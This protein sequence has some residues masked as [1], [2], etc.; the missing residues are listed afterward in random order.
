MA[1]VVREGGKIHIILASNPV[2]ATS[3]ASDIFFL[4]RFPVYGGSSGTT[5]LP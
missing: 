1:F 2:V 4:C 5:E 3:L